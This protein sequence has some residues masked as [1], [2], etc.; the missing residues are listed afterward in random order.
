MLLSIPTAIADVLSLEDLAP[1]P[2]VNEVMSGLVASVVGDTKTDVQVIDK[3]LCAQVRQ[4]SADAETEMENYWAKKI[5]TAR[6][7]T[8][9]LHQFPYLDNYEE[10][11]RREVAL[12]KKSGLTLS[13]K[14]RVLVV[15]SGPLPLSGIELAIQTGTIVE[16]VDISPRAMELG[17]KVNNMLGHDAAYY[18]ASG[19]DVVLAAHYDAILIAA[20]AGDSLRQKQ[21]IVDNVLPSLK[22]RGRIVV[23]SA[24]GN[25][26]LLYPAVTAASFRGMRLLEE[27]HPDDYVIN[28][29]FVYEREV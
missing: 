13:K 28:S 5:I 2:R 15:G 27:Y 17:S 9:M 8:E 7:P 22:R 29:V 14:S 1:S 19:Q 24:K 11:T 4:K 21:A 6:Q 23:R 18:I 25:R 12:I 20:L 26:R 3:K 10:L 16:A